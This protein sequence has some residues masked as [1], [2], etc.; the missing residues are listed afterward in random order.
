MEECV[1]FARCTM[2]FRVI[3]TVVESMI[4]SSS[5]WVVVLLRQNKKRKGE[6]CKKFTSM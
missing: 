6:K 4:F 3:V 1:L 5:F 2:S